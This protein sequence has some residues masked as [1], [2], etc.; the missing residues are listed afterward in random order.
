MNG[1]TTLILNAMIFAATMTAHAGTIKH[2]FVAT[3]ESGKQLLY[4]DEFNPAND[5]TI[6]LPGNRDL[7]VVDKTTVI[8]SVPTGFREY[9][10][11]DGSMT[12]EVTLEGNVSGICSVI[13]KPDGTT[14]LAN[15]E[16]IFLLDQEDKIISE[17]PM[18]MGGFFRLLRMTKSGNFLFTCNGN[19]IREA[20]PD[21]ETVYELNLLTIDPNCNKPYFAEPMGDD[22]LLISTGYGSALL[23]VDKERK[24]VQKYGGKG[25]I[26]EMQLVFFA[27]AQQLK[28]GHLA[29]A[30]WTGHGRQDSIKAPQA[31]EFDKD[32]TLVWQWH[33]PERAGSLHGIEIIEQ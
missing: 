31:L 25:S 21:G 28:N 6:P 17:I 4:V 27:D 3:D 29:V 12:K 26:P 20:T 18:N 15:K 14:I 22:Q 10:L 23:V 5:W 11:K 24:L 2:T 8:V 13:R 7:Q 32:G 19:S 1:S 9:A 30:H 16:K 33:D